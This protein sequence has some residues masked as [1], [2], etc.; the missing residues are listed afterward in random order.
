MPFE[1]VGGNTVAPFKVALTLN[2]LADA[3]K[4]LRE[5]TRKRNV[6]FMS[7]SPLTPEGELRDLMV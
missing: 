2:N 1:L 3:E 5:K 4:R 6:F 7:F